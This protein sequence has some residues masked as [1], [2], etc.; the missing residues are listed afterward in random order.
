MSSQ[1]CLSRDVKSDMHRNV[2]DYHPNV[3]RVGETHSG[4]YLGCT[5]QYDTIFAYNQ[6]NN[7][8]LEFF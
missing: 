4:F 3:A 8:G 7:I 1:A 2:V 5:I 6:L